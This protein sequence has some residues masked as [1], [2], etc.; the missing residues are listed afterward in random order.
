MASD[1][2]IG[3]EVIPFGITTQYLSGF[4]PTKGIPHHPY[5]D[6][7]RNNIRFLMTREGLNELAVATRAGIHQ[8]WLTR[9]MKGKIAKPNTEKLGSVAMALGVNAN[10][11]MFS[12]LTQP[13]AVPSSQ[14]TQLEREI[15]A[16]AVKLV[17]E[18][19]ALSPVPQDPSTF[20]DR[21]AIAGK[22][23]DKFGHAGIMDGSRLNDA[24]RH[25]AAD[26]RKAG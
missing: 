13:G 18:L 23:V 17:Q 11:L 15:M 25:F 26:L 21:L 19:E 24:L 3:R 4:C 20:S 6:I 8:S 10:Q 5:M 2:F 9:Y 14:P 22:A 7:V 12:D 1:G 16:A